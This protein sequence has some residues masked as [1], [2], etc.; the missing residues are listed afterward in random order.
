MK[1]FILTSL[2]L[3]ILFVG[4]I[5]AQESSTH[6]ISQEEAI[7]AAPDPKIEYVK[8]FIARSLDAQK[9]YAAS[10]E[11][12]KTEKFRQSV[13]KFKDSEDYTDY[14][15]KAGFI[16]FRFIYKPEFRDVI[17]KLEITLPH[18]NYDGVLIGG[19]Y[20]IDELVTEYIGDVEYVNPEKYK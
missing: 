17:K 5:S 10:L 13:S 14:I 2:V 15:Y 16:E 11:Y 3:T 6:A 8:S 9:A 4:E 1:K 7:V 18:L 20:K 12:E 19:D